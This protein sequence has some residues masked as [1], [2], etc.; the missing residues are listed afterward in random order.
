MQHVLFDACSLSTHALD[1]GARAGPF[2]GVPATGRTVATQEFAM[3]RVA[4][5]ERSARLV[6]NDNA[7]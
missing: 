3:Y 2:L 6:T 5:R 1:T 4:A 7:S